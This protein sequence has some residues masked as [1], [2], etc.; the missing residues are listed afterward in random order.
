MMDECS[1]RSLHQTFWCI[2]SHLQI[3]RVWDEVKKVSDYATRSADVSKYNAEHKYR[4]R[5]IAITPVK[6]GIAFTAKF[7][8]QVM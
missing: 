2:T 8:N 1:A 7:L 3:A 4:K 6:F 5:G